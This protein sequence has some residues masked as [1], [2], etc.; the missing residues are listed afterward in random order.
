M[1]KNLWQKIKAFFDRL[2]EPTND[3]GYFGDDGQR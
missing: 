1:L 3:G 2:T